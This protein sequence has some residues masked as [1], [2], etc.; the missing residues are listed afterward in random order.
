MV[1]LYLLCIICVEFAQEYHFC[2][3]T[4]NMQTN[5]TVEHWIM[6][7]FPRTKTTETDCET[8]GFI[9]QKIMRL[10]TSTGMHIVRHNNCIQCT[11]NM[12]RMKLKYCCNSEFQ[13]LSNHH[14]VRET[15]SYNLI[16][17]LCICIA[18][19]ILFYALNTP[20]I[21]ETFIYIYKH[22]LFILQCTLQS[23]LTQM[24]HRNTH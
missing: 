1:R 19:C 11:L 5:Y 22:L 7:L 18:L 16:F 8:R 6:N 20:R 9:T 21:S 12:Q 2:E 10:S 17:I 15:S 4:I 14:L 3:P 23:K 13:A 24:A